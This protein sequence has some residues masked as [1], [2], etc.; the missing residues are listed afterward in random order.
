MD[1]SDFVR[2]LEAMPSV[3][4]YEDADDGVFVACLLHPTAPPVIHI[5]DRTIAANGW[6]TLEAACVQGCNV[7]HITRTTGYFS[8]TSGWNKGKVGELKDRHRSRGL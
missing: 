5:P 2:E 8:K 1:R 4:D 7:D 6:D 3:F